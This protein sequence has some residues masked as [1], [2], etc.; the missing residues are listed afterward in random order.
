M[1][2]LLL[3]VLAGFAV[4]FLFLSKDYGVTA[5]LF[6]RVVASASF[7]FI[8]LDVLWKYFAVARAAQNRRQRRPRRRI[9]EVG[10]RRWRC[11]RVTSD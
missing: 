9:T 1:E 5:A 4:L 3:V 11:K 7:V 10:L 8:A 2:A 6:P